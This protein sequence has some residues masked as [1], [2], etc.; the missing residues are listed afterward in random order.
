MHLVPP[1]ATNLDRALGPDLQPGHGSHDTPHR[2]RDVALAS[3]P[4]MHLRALRSG[5]AELVQQ[6]FDQLSADSRYLRFHTGMPHLPARLLRYLS[7]LTQGA[8]E[9]VVAAVDGQAVGLAR[10]IR[11]T[12]RPATAELAVAVADDY[13]GRGVGKALVSAAARTARAAGIVSFVCAVHPENAVALTALRA[14]GARTARNPDLE[15]HLPVD[16]AAEANPMVGRGAVVIP[17]PS[18]VR[19][20]GT[21]PGGQ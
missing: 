3:A 15:L 10:W 4:V 7:T 13:Q 8:H 14:A 6:V 21:A 19:G 1:T 9:A 11:L 18:A 17:L 20:P 2:H 5:D 12:G 16:V